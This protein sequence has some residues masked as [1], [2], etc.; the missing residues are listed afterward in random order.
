MKRQ[1]TLDIENKLNEIITDRHRN[2]SFG[3]YGCEEVT[4]GF[5]NNGHGNEIVDFMSMDSKGIIRCYEIKVT[6]ADFKSKAKLS[7]YG[8]YNYLVIGGELL[9]KLD[10]VK[11]LTPTEIGIL[12]NNLSAIRRP[13]LKGI[14]TTTETMLKESL[15]RSMYHKMNKYKRTQDINEYKKLES[16]VKRIERER[17]KY[18]KQYDDLTNDIWKYEQWLR[19]NKG[20]DFCLEDEFEKMKGR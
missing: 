15:V 6:M 3:Y 19:R 7:F 17:N 13:K 18:K 5:A 2:S 16:K 20:I 12:D 8:H 11:L 9:D 1:E 4:I 10:E 14:H